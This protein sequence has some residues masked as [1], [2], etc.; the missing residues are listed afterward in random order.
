MKEKIEHKID[1]L[2]LLP[3]KLE[4][5]IKPTGITKC[6]EFQHIVALF[7][8]LKEELTKEPHNHDIETTIEDGYLI[9]RIEFKR[10]DY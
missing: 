3:P 10:N 1:L 8:F 9:L 4:I 7:S 6:I 2:P 5:K